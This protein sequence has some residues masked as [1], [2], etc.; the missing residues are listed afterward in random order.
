M[1]CPMPPRGPTPTEWILAELG[2]KQPWN[3]KTFMRNKVTFPLKKSFPSLTISRSNG[4]LEP[5]AV[6]AK[7]KCP[8]NVMK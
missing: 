8:F 6:L 3:F 5:V 7:K 2:Y 1:V 4:K